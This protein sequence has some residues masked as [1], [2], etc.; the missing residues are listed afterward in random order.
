M[1][2]DLLTLR[3]MLVAAPD[4]T[5]ELWRAGVALASLPIELSIADATSAAK[6]G[7]AAFDVVIFDAAIAPAERQNVI[8]AASPSRP[9]PLIAAMAPSEPDPPEGVS[10]VFQTPANAAAVRIICER[11][12]RMRVPKRVLVVD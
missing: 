12:I 8:N 2:G 11:C 6:S 5:E 1:S 4:A 3:M 9:A 7:G 10:V